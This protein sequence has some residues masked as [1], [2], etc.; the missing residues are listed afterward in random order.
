[1]RWENIRVGYRSSVQ[2]FL[3]IFMVVLS[4]LIWM[5]SLRSIGQAD[6]LTLKSPTTSF[7]APSL[8]LCILR[9]ELKAFNR[10]NEGDLFQRDIVALCGAE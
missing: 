4:L 2:A 5:S 9:G 1:M 3:E 8:W 6:T 10:D 7:L